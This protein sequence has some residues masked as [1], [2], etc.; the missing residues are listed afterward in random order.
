MPSAIPVRCRCSNAV[1]RETSAVSNASAC[2]ANAV[3]VADL[4]HLGIAVGAAGFEHERGRAAGPADQRGDPQLTDGIGQIVAVR[5]VA[6]HARPGGAD[7]ESCEA[8]GDIEICT[9]GKPGE[10]RRD[11]QVVFDAGVARPAP[12]RTSAPS[13]ARS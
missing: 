8:D 13:V 7:T 3:C 4:Q 9:T 10:L 6:Q 2:W 1:Q 11:P 12:R 5:V